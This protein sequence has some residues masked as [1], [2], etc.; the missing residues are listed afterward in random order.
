MLSIYYYSITIEHDLFM[1][2]KKAGIC[3]SHA[4]EEGIKMALR[5]HRKLGLDVTGAKEENEK[6]VEGG[7]DVRRDAR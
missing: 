4:A 1:D 7:K 5:E 2:A 3:M 6:N